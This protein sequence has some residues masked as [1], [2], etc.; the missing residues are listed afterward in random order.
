MLA[1]KT[2]FVDVFRRLFVKPHE[3]LAG[4]LSFLA[5]LLVAFE[6]NLSADA[7]NH[8]AKNPLAKPD[9]IFDPVLGN[10]R[11][12][13]TLRRVL[14]FVERRAEAPNLTSWNPRMFP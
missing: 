10:V 4:A 3:Y 2:F 7:Q 8:F 6:R 1:H 12:E 9:T 14:L 13:F 5:S 11:Q